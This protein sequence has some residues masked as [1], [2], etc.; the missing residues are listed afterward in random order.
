MI[1]RYTYPEMG[2]IWTDENEFQT[3]LDIEI[4]A[5]E[6]MASGA[7]WLCLVGLGLLVYAFP[8]HF[9]VIVLIA[10]GFVYYL[11]THRKK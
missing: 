7:R 9:L 11:D 1:E 5:C 3:M 10:A 8:L 4:C 2:R 6:I